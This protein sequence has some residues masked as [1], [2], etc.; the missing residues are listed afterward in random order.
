MDLLTL[1]QPIYWLGT[2]CVE[3]TDNKACISIICIEIQDLNGPSA[4]IVDTSMVSCNGFNDGSATVDMIGGNGFFTALWDVNAGSQTTPTAS[5]L[6]AGFYAVTITDSIGCNASISIEITE[7]DVMI[8][9]Q[10][11]YNTICFGSCDGIASLA[12]IGGTQP[13]SY[14]WLDVNNITVGTV[15]SIGGLCAGSYTLS[16]VDIRDVPIY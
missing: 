7:P 15:D 12:T 10:T 11:F 14:S 13:Y 5:N 1:V 2:Y 4:M 8:S 16:I 6:A 9:I 3:V